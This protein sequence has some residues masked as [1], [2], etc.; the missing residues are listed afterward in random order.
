[1]TER[2]EDSNAPHIRKMTLRD[3][4]E[5]YE[6]GTGIAEFAV[7]DV[8]SFWEKPEL[9]SWVR[10]GKDDVLLVAEADSRIA[11]FILT[12]FHKPTKSC[13]FANILVREEYRRRGIGEALMEEAKAQVIDKGA[14]Y[15]FAVAQSANKASQGLCLAAG[16]KR[17][18]H[19]TWLE[20]VPK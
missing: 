3:I 15:I 4:D 18:H 8:S 14:T 12:K 19:M 17:G 5:V 6:M 13:E 10:E 16:F 7:S 2:K 9:E 20:Y 1:M 11:G